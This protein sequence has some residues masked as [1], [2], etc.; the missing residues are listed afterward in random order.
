MKNFTSILFL[1]LP[2]GL[3][4]QAEVVFDS[5][6]KYRFVCKSYGTGA[7]VLGENHGSTAYLYYDISGPNSED[8]WWYISNYGA[9]YT[10][11]NAY[12]EEYITYYAT[13]ITDVAKGLALTSEVTGDEC[14]W[15]FSEQDNGYVIIANV[16]QPTQWWNQRIDGTYLLGTYAYNEGTDNELFLIYDENGNLVTS[17]ENSDGNESDGGNTETTKSFSETVDTLRIHGKDLVYDQSSDLY[18]LPIPSVVEKGGSWETMVQFVPTKGNEDLHLEIGGTEIDEETGA[19]TIENVDCEEPLELALVDSEGVTQATAELQLTWLPIVEIGYSS[20]NS[21]TYSSGTIR[22]TWTDHTAYDST[23]IAYFRFRGATALS[24]EKKAYAIKLRDAVGESVNRSYL[25]LRSDN[26]WILDAATVDPS[27]M[28]NRVATDL[29]NDFANKPYYYDDEPN[30]LT[31]T[32]GRFV[33]VFLNG[34][35]HGVYC[36]TEKMDRKQ[37]KLKKYKSAEESD[38]GEEEIRG[39]LY[40][41]TDWSYEVF[42]GHESDRKQFPSRSPSSYSNTLGTETWRGFELKY[43]DYEEEAVEWAPLYNAV[44]FVATSSQT[45][46]EADLDEWFDR[47]VLDDYYL[48]IDLLLATDNHGK[49]MYYF[50]YNRQGSYGDLLSMAPWD[51]DGTWGGR[52]DG[53]TNLTSDATQDLEDFLWAYEHGQLTIFYKLLN[54]TSFDWT[55]SLAKRYAELR[56]TYFNPDELVARFQNYAEL[57]SESL[58]DEREESR[59]PSIHNDIASAVE[60]IEEWIPARVAALDEKYGYDPTLKGINSAKAE[61]YFSATGGVGRIYLNVGTD[62]EVSIFTLG[63][64][65]L[66]RVEAHTGHSSI[67]GLIPGVYVVNGRKVLV[68]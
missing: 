3:E 56:P 41:S 11:Q 39:V 51:L 15:T 44:N 19:V 10:I 37:L 22:V 61:A 59:W 2:L 29:W 5:D 16:E 55:E 18:F 35:Y 50:V 27:G 14:L 17:E 67:G 58:A 24:Y 52:W 65:L 23:T 53:S 36:M 42:M 20:C 57:L 30:A 54:A 48:F 26:N 64:A 63:G 49:N 68:R 12:S 6:T 46:F 4:L 62:C 21:S 31:G 66:K 1:L 32:R 13:R 60:Y 34:T 28:R 33:E 25:G 47:P 9:G 38:S 8:A 45:N 43:P 40:K 7:V